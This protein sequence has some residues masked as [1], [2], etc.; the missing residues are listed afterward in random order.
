M[1]VGTEVIYGLQTPKILVKIKT[2][3]HIVEIVIS[4]SVPCRKSR[5]ECFR[6]IRQMALVSY[7]LKRYS[8]CITFCADKLICT[9]SNKYN[10]EVNKFDLCYVKQTSSFL[11][12]DPIIIIKF[13]ERLTLF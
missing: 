3:L 8:Y 6:R 13:E 4:S 2:R 12:L 1:N 7:F 10:S 9:E 11:Y 5:I